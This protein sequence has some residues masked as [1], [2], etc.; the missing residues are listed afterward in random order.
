V[1]TCGGVNFRRAAAV[2][3]LLR[4][5][6]DGVDPAF[7]FRGFVVRDELTCM[8]QMPSMD[9][10]SHYPHVVA[11][12]EELAA[13]ARTFAVAMAA[14]LLLP[15]GS[16]T[17]LCRDNCLLQGLS[18]PLFFSCFFCGCLSWYVGRYQVRPMRDTMVFTGV[19]SA[20]TNVI[21][22]VPRP[23]SDNFLVTLSPVFLFLAAA[24][25]AG[26]FQGEYGALHTSCSSSTPWRPSHRARARMIHE[27]GA[28]SL[29]RCSVSV[30]QRATVEPVLALIAFCSM[31]L[32]LMLGLGHLRPR[33]ATVGGTREQYR[34]ASDVSTFV[35]I[36]N[37]VRWSLI[38]QR[39]PQKLRQP[40]GQEDIRDK[41]E[42]KD[43]EAHKGN[44]GPLGNIPSQPSRNHNEKLTKDV[45]GERTQIRKYSTTGRRGDLRQ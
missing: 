25:E 1:W 39:K 41:R 22:A 40:T 6:V 13:S 44:R 38:A 28:L 8:S 42:R 9:V 3:V 37:P 26:C 16:A 14:P 2:P 36:D 17:V 19:L 32:P 33:S 29:V 7:E 31:P 10:Y 45:A 24:R 18:P 12:R 35:F 20:P 5:W 15:S 34:A 11:R 27:A 4:K 43:L 30:P 23:F 21:R